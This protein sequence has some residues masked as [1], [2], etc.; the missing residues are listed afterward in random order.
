MA[1][2][3]QPLALLLALA[4]VALGLASVVALH[5]RA[6]AL[7]RRAFADNAVT[8]LDRPPVRELVTAEIADRL[9]AAAPVDLLPRA[10]VEQAAGRVV[11]TRGFRRAF[12]RSAAEANRV[13][14]DGTADAAALRLESV[15][16]ALAGVDPRLAQLLPGDASLQLLTLRRGTVGVGT[17]ELADRVE[18]TARVAPW[19]A[20]AALAGALLLAAAR[21]RLLAATGA[22]VAAAGIVLLIALPLGRGAVE[23]TV[24]T[25]AAVDPATARAAAGQVYDVYAD[26]LQL[27]GIVAI[28]GGLMVLAAATLLGGR[29]G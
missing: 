21:R 4:A 14:F 5:L 27:Y 22:L 17:V 9:L 26:G 10:T 13:L 6:E 23:R 19:L 3:R 7:D 8:A 20:L 12:R 2:A 1:G 16:A 25:A 29:R 15:T 11:E 18:T 28:G 24:D